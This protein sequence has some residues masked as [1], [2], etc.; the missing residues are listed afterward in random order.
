MNRILLLL[1]FVTA[2]FTASCKEK[3]SDRSE[4]TPTEKQVQSS[5]KI[6]AFGDS[7]TAGMNL[8]LAESYPAYLQKLVD[9]DGFHYEVVNAGVSGDTST[10]GLERLDWTLDAA[11]VKIVILELGAND[12][13]RGIEISLLKKNLAQMIERAQSRG[14]K[15]ILAGIEAP[16]NSGP[17][18][19]EQVHRA[20]RELAD[21][22]KVPFMPFFL[23]GII[24][25]DSLIQ[26]DG[27]HL[28]KEGNRI[29]AANVYKKVKPLLQEIGRSEGR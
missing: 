3:D 18:Y 28:T 8:P 16:T 24:G 9:A 7:L 4:S 14:A 21:Q 1:L 12:I 11:D 2:F 22:Y 10:G 19:R 26:E 5:G 17:E 25:N 6:V 13:L 27:T 29:L 15:V 20:Y 23:E